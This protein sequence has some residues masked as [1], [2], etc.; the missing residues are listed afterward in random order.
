[1]ELVDDTLRREPNC[2][3][4]QLCAALNGNV[5]KLIELAVGIVMIRLPRVSTDLWD[6]EINAEWQVRP[7]KVG[8]HFSNDF[9]QL[10]RGV[11]ETADDAEAARVRHGGRELS[12]RYTRHACQ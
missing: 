8:L 2:T 11:L 10:V 12:A 4:E 6:R 9:A 7:S 1:M 5:D 3:D